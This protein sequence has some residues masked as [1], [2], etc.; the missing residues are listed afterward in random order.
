MGTH[1]MNALPLLGCIACIAFVA[2]FVTTFGL[3]WPGILT[4]TV[5]SKCGSDNY[6]V[7]LGTG[8]YYICAGRS[9]TQTDNNAQCTSGEMSGQSASDVW[10]GAKGLVDKSAAISGEGNALNE[11]QAYC[12]WLTCDGLGYF[13]NYTGIDSDVCNYVRGIYV[14]GVVFIILGMFMVCCAFHTRKIAYGSALFNFVAGLLFM[15]NGA[16]MTT[17]SKG[18]DDNAWGYSYYILWIGWI[19]AWVITAMT[20]FAGCAKEDDKE[21]GSAQNATV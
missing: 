11:T 8:L 14:A 4:Y 17:E 9:G 13:G 18:G 6:D 21:G 20:L 15:A 3:A 19:F 5:A 10:E 2:A 7:Y 16:Y 12:A 1:T